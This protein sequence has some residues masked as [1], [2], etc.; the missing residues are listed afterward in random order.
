M[1]EQERD[2]TPV[3]VLCEALDVSKS[4]FYNWRNRPESSRA[5]EDRRLSVE[6]R[7]VHRESR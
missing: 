2:G 7:A 4:G 6:I 5:I 1:I 3:R